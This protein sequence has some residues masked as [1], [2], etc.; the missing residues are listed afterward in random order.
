M[1]RRSRCRGS[2]LSRRSCWH[3]R[4]PTA[5]RHSP[6]RS[7]SDISRHV[8]RIAALWSLGSGETASAVA[9]GS[10]ALLML[11]L[12]AMHPPAGIAAFL[13]AGLGLPT[14]WAMNPVLVGAVLLAS[15]ARVWSIG[16]RRLALGSAATEVAEGAEP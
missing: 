12:R 2:R 15:F 14:S 6:T 3:L 16:E 11:A 1:S 10:A 13:V 9:V 5:S 8:S 4:C 7:L